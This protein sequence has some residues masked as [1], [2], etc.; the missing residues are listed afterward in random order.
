MKYI[1]LL[2]FVCLFSCQQQSKNKADSKTDSIKNEV[3]N[4]HNA[5]N[6]LDYIG[7]YKGILPCADCQGLDTEIAINENG[8]FS[9]K[10]KYQGK[11]DKVFVQKGHFTWNKKG[12]IIVLTDIKN[13]PNQYFVAENKLIQLDISGK[14]ISGNLA[15]DYV[16]SK[17]AIDTSAIETAEES[18]VTVDLDS[19]IIT[20]TV[21]EK[22]N[23]AVG[24]YPLAGTKWK[25][26]SLRK[27]KAAQKGKNVYYMKLNSKDGRFVAL[28]GCNNILGHYVMPS[29]TSLTFSGIVSNKMDCA[30]AELESYFFTTLAETNSYKLENEILILFGADKK[31]LAKFEVIK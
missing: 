16:L 13:G 5:K 21:I 20:T 25:L 11:G 9:I 22:V 3:L 31:Q 14:K 27:I 1:L 29:S 4:S 10:T 24:K 18:K 6:S 15:E 19:R 17:Q 26:V 28:S 8:T 23:P 2:I 30:D 12:N 7:T